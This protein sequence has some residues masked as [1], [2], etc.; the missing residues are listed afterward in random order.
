MREQVIR[1]EKIFEG[2]VVNLRVDTIRLPNGRTSQRE[3]VEHRGAVAIVPLLDE[4]TVLMIRQFRLAVNEVLLEVPAGTL[5]P[6]EPPIVCAARELEEETGYRA[7]T[8]R[9]LFS[10]YLAPGYSQEILH[11]FLAQGLEK[12]AQRTEEDESVEVVPVPL[13]RAVELVL[14]GEIRDAK[15]IAALLVTY[16]LLTSER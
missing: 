9:P 14:S 3:I 15:T 11:V 2:R 8:L 16:Y 6:N 12:T 10:Q 7:S 4:E 13:A 5:E 1:S